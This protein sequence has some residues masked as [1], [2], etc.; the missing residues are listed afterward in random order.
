MEAVGGGAESGLGVLGAGVVLVTWL[1]RSQ[2]GRGRG[3]R[4]GVLDVVPLVVMVS[5][6]GGV[7]GTGGHPGAALIA[8]VDDDDALPVVVVAGLDEEHLGAV[9]LVVQ[10]VCDADLGLAALLRGEVDGEARALVVDRHAGVAGVAS[11]I[12]VLAL[13][14]GH[15]LVRGVVDVGG[16]GGAAEGPVGVGGDLVLGLGEEEDAAGCEIRL[17]GE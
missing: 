11:Y 17:M 2:E 8:G 9:L 15:G 6:V 12:W 14:R 7:E 1:G 3:I 5:A 10:V 4:Q 16:I 13:R